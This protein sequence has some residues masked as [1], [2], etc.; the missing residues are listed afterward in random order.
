MCKYWSG[1]CILALASIIKKNVKKL[2]RQQ[3]I[4]LAI[5]KQLIKQSIVPSLPIV[6][7]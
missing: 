6:E 7:Q 3:L 4:A 2:D 5:K 1:S